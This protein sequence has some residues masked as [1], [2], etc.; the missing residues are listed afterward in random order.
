MHPSSLFCTSN[1]PS[2]KPSILKCCYGTNWFSAFWVL[3]RHC[4]KTLLLVVKLWKLDLFETFPEFPLLSVFPVPHL[5]LMELEGCLVKTAIKG[6]FRNPLLLVGCTCLLKESTR[7]VENFNL[8]DRDTSGLNFWKCFS[9]TCELELIS[10]SRSIVEIWGFCSSSNKKL[11]LFSF[12]ATSVVVELWVSSTCASE[13]GWLPSVISSIT[14]LSTWLIQR[15]CSKG[16][17][18]WRLI[19]WESRN[20][21]SPLD[22]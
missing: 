10:V 20:Y 19:R 1:L 6:V 9:L 8:P 5:F 11:T 2:S 12:E 15:F 17:L 14:K 18:H 4:L 22:V 16:L 7:Q 3:R 21:F 13:L